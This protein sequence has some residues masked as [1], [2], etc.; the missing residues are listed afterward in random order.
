MPDSLKVKGL[1]FRG[2]YKSKKIKMPDWF[3][4]GSILESDDRE[5]YAITQDTSDWYLTPLKASSSE[6]SG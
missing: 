4:H 1:D 2:E 5:F 3:Q 6:Q